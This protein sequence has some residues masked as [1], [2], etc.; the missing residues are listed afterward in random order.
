MDSKSHDSRVR[1]A[2]R[3]GM[4]ELDMFLL[5][6]FDN[7]YAKLNTLEQQAFQSL[8]G[9]A[10]PLLQKWLLEQAVPQEAAQAQLIAKIIDYARHHSQ[11]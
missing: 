3:R 7:E 9:E 6:F 5:P 1:W 11:S 4:L 8:L 2:C 10:D